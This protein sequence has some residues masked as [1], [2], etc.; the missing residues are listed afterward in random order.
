MV[1][2]SKPHDYVKTSKTMLSVN[3]IEQSFIKY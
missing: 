1:D 3:Y 2:E